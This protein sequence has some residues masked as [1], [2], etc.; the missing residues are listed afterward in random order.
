MTRMRRPST[1]SSYE[2]VA[3]LGTVTRGDASEHDNAAQIEADH[4]Q[5]SR[6]ESMKES[7]EERAQAAVLPVVGI[8]PS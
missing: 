1:R 6:T 5:D 7:E 2:N 8:A 3:S 4:T